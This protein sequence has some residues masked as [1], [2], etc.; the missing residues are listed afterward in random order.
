MCRATL[1]N[2]RSGSVN[3]KISLKQSRELPNGTI[4][5]KGYVLAFLLLSASIIPSRTYSAEASTPGNRPT[6]T[7]ESRSTAKI[8]AQGTIEPIN[9]ANVCAQVPERIVS[10]GSVPRSNG[11][12]IN[13][14]SAVDVG[15]VLAQLDDAPYLML[16]EQE[17]AKCRV[18]ETELAHAK[19]KLEFAETSWK[20]VENRYK[21]GTIK[22]SEY[23]AS[24]YERQLAK[25]SVA[26]AEAALVKARTDCK[27]AQL[28]LSYTT[29]KSPIKG[30]VIAR[31]A[32]VGQVANVGPNAP[33]LFLIADTTR[34]EIWAS[35]NEADISRIH[36]Q[37]PVRF[38]VD[39]FPGKVFE[40]KVKQIRQNA[41]M[42]EN[43]VV[44]TVVIAI[45]D[46]PDAGK[47]LPYLTARVEF[48]EQGT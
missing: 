5:K 17:Q 40:G 41:A 46:S 34:L 39:A 44:F 19:I 36:Q 21:S 29:L 26:V 10:L 38:T 13:Y 9:V 32:N 3:L 42:I 12:T 2:Q 37:Q 35:V 7:A 15:T 23:L 30:I 14:G 11:K 4:M 31:R 43:I 22:E 25:A 8:V 47:L 20:S 33:S 24:K 18:A 45:S 27:A 1:A 28:K 6:K 48:A 16:V